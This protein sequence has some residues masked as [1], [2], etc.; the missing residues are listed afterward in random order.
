MG[1]WPLTH[2]V[3]AKRNKK[4]LA[5]TVETEPIESITKQVIKDCLIKHVKAVEFHKCN[6]RN[7]ALIAIEIL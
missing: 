3:E 6:V 1:M 5:G 2:E 7:N 4:K